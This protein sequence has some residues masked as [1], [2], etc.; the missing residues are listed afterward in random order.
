MPK[1]TAG[2]VIQ[3]VRDALNDPNAVRWT[4]TTLYRYILAGEQLMAGNHPETQLSDD[5]PKVDFPTPVLLSNTTDYTTISYEH[6]TSLVH[7]VVARC[8]LE[9]ADDSQN[10]K[11]A[12]RHMQLYRETLGDVQVR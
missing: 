3:E 8:F 12:E 7:F 4:N 6:H 1:V 9:D 10:A 2:Q 11:L 5:D